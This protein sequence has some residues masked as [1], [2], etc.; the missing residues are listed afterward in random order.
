MLQLVRV[1]TLKQVLHW[2]TMLSGMSR[3]SESST[4]EISLRIVWPEAVFYP[5]GVVSVPSGPVG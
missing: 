5:F 3:N 4:I 1:E 2:H